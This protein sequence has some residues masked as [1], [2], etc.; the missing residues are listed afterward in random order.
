MVWEFIRPG[1]S[2]DRR[3][4]QGGGANRVLAR[5]GVLATFRETPLAGARVGDSL[6]PARP[7]ASAVD[8]VKAQQ[9]Y[10]EQGGVWDA[11][12][13]RADDFDD[14]HFGEELDACVE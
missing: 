8:L 4:M 11:V 10:V 12:H 7:A 14:Q 2:A 3:E 6:W 9:R 13:G 1:A 5:V